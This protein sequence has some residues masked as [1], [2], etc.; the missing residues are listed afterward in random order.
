MLFDP[1]PI[2]LVLVGL[3]VG[4]VGTWYGLRKI[5]SVTTGWR[6][7]L[8]RAGRAR[9]MPEERMITQTIA[10]RVRS[11]GK[12]VALEVCAK[13]I[14]TASAGWGWMPPL[15]LSQARLAMIFHFEKQYSLDLGQIRPED[16]AELEPGRF[17]LRL[18]EMDGALRLID[19]T[20]YDIQAARILGLLDLIP[21]T[22][23]RQRDLMKK[24]QAEA[25][26]IFG[27]SDRKYLGEARLS[28]ERHL[29]A[30]MEMMGVKVEF[31]WPERSR[32]T[33]VHPDPPPQPAQAVEAA[34]KPRLI[35]PAI[36]LNPARA[37]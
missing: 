17:R 21:M 32:V 20:P 1:T 28:A 11:V 7:R 15:I 14:T 37:G 18:P 10:E 35:F 24:A 8:S 12:L 31:E 2:V 9:T 34:P 30:L 6:G 5:R 26:S 13:E 3:T 4:G 16:V 19:M 25:A 33:V 27:N 23:D 29:R 22:A 36:V